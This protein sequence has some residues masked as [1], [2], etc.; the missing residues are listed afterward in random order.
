MLLCALSIVASGC[1]VSSPPSLD[2]NDLVK[3]DE[4]QD[5]PFE[6][7]Y[8]VSAEKNSLVTITALRNGSYGV[9]QEWPGKPDQTRHMTASFMYL[10]QITLVGDRTALRYLL[11]LQQGAQVY[12]R[13]LIFEP[14]AGRYFWAFYGPVEA[15]VM[16]KSRFL[17]EAGLALEDR[18]T[19]HY[20]RSLD[21]GPPTSA[22]LK[23][24]FRG[25]D[26]AHPTEFETLQRVR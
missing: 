5:I 16:Q 4:R 15:N 1:L 21:G 24:L 14:A 17:K 2:P 19:H 6:G 25:S 12:Y 22:Q 11:I 13:N 3:V 8:T 18:S 7:V 20:L 9:Q 26:V 23:V 10:D